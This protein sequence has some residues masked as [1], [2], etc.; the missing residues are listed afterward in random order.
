M[1]LNE[2]REGGFMVMLDIIIIF[3]VI[4]I[5]IIIIMDYNNYIKVVSRCTL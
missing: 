4:I 1:M 2:S 5:I 3:F